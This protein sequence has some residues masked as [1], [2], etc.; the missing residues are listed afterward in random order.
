MKVG[1]MAK[2]EQSVTINAPVEKVFSYMEPSGKKKYT[3]P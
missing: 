1:G 2:V 3:I